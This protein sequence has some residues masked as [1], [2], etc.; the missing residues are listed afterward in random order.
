MIHFSYID[1]GAGSILL[2]ALVGG[3]LGVVYVGRRFLRR[4]G[5]AVKTRLTGKPR[6]SDQTED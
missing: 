1:P 4:A 6:V 2:Q 3:A 5:D